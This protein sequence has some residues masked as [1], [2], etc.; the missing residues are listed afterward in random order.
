MTTDRLKAWFVHLFTASGILTV[1]M[2]LIE[3]GEKDFRAAMLWLIAAQVIDGIDGTLARRYRV[4]EVLPGMSGKS[5]DFVIDFAGY[6]VVPAYMIYQAQLIPGL[7]GLFMTLLIV[8][9]SAI[10]Y[11]KNSMIT[12]DLY[13]QGF[14]VIWNMVAFYLIFMFNFPALLNT[15]LITFLTVMQFLPVKFAYP[16]LTKRWRFATLLFTALL[17]VSMTGMLIFYPNYPALLYWGPIIS[18]DYFAVFGFAAT[19]IFKD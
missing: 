11:G 10:Y 12:D 19:F 3:T 7:P 6:C 16:S 9:T 5:I 8:L 2:A 4:E 14:P 17:L 15:I 13:F 1:F 18:L